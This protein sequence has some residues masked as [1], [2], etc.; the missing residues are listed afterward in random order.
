MAG[1]REMLELG[2]PLA[3]CEDG[4][5]RIQPEDGVDHIGFR[6]TV[7]VILQLGQE[8]KSSGSVRGFRGV[9]VRPPEPSS[10]GFS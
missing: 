8:F 10:S 6:G 3:Q 1:L 4:R 9:G 7:I 2:A 5:G